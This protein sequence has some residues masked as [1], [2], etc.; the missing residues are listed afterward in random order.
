MGLVCLVV[1]PALIMLMWCTSR[2][3]AL[4]NELKAWRRYGREMERAARSREQ[5]SQM[6]QEA[7]QQVLRRANGEAFRT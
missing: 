4:E 1:I 7:R 5:V 6:L 2:I 3:S